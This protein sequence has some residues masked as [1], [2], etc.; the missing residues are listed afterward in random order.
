MSLSESGYETLE[1]TCVAVL[2]VFLKARLFREQDGAISDNCPNVPYHNRLLA[3]RKGYSK[4]D[5]ITRPTI[6]RTGTAR[7]LF[8]FFSFFAWTALASIMTWRFFPFIYFIFSACLRSPS[9]AERHV[10]ACANRDPIVVRETGN[11]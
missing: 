11:R 8:F 2:R 4:I 9:T 6:R 5:A 10:L 3:G 1:T 7:F